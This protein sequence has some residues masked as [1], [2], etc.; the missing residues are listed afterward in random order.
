MEEWLVMAMDA[1]A[2]LL[3]ILLIDLV[4]F[5][6]SYAVTQINPD[7][8]FWDYEGS[9]ISKADTGDG[10]YEV[11]EVSATDIPDG[12]QAVDPDNQ[13]GFFTDIFRSVRNWIFSNVPGAEALVS[14][15]NAL[16]NFLKA[17]GLPQ[18][19]VFGVGALWHT[20]GVFLLI[21]FVWGRP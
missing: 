16:P 13:A 4:L 10:D 11:R 18:V 15:V 20:L 12:T 1:K 7:S 14:V 2:M 8:G 3:L 9:L 19:F 6:G 5:F 17:I 21:S